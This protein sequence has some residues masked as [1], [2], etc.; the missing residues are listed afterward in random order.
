MSIAPNKQSENTQNTNS[1]NSTSLPSNEPPQKRTWSVDDFEFHECLG[2]GKFGYVY[3]A[4]EKR[5]SKEV[6]I[7]LINKNIV[8]Q[9]DMLNQ[10]KNEI[11][12]HTRLK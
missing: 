6:A 2:N 8:T 9:Y 7:K 1:S 10:L 4:K 5:T 11:E 12:I 3:H